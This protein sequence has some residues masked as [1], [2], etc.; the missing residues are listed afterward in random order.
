MSGPLL[1]PPGHQT[2]PLARSPEALLSARATVAA[3]MLLAALWRLHASYGRMLWLDELYTTTLIDT[4]SLGH[5]W[6]GVMRGV[7]GNPPLYMSLAWA[8]THAIQIAPELVLRPFNLVLLAATATLLYRL[9]RRVATPSAVVVALALLPALDDCVA[10]ALLETRTY[11]LYLFLVTATLAAALNVLDR[12]S[13]GRLA[14]LAGVGLATSFSHSFG[15]FYVLATLGAAGLAC[16]AASD[17]KCAAGFVFAALPSLLASAAWILFL[18]PVMRASATPYSWVPKPDAAALFEAISGSTSLAFALALALGVVG[19]VVLACLDPR[20]LAKF[21]SLRR[22]VAALYAAL[23]GYVGL[24]VAGWVGSQVI[25]PFF[26]P[27]YFI[28]NVII[29]ALLL[30]PAAELARR[31]SRPALALAGSI[32]CILLG[33]WTLTRDNPGYLIPCLDEGGHFLEAEAARGGLPVVAESPHSWLPRSRYATGQT[34]LYPLDWRVVLDWPNRARNNA[35]DYHI[36]EALRSWAAPGTVL[37]ENILSTDEILAKYR[38]FLVL[39]EAPRAWFDVVSART[40]VSVKLLGKGPGC[41]LW[42]V[43]RSD[44]AQLGR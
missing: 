5:V 19:V 34:T 20:L 8:L 13:V 2:I 7:D 37:S 41:R 6:D 22:D 44:A 35:M 21:Q 15:G 14:A 9:G 30:I 33:L 29:V 26:V 38:R 42:E 10:Y 11:A 1:S 12:P 31:G 39:D 3:G 17:R 24:T 4:P 36:M 28:P 40:P 43:S 16:I 18:Y 23:A 32:V 27:R 25:T